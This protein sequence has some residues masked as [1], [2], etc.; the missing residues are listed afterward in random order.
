MIAKCPICNKE[1]SFYPSSKRKYCCLAC[2]PTNLG[3]MV[4]WRDKIPV[5]IV[6]VV[7]RKEFYVR[8]NKAVGGRAKYC[9]FKCKQVGCGRKGGEIIGNQLRGTGKSYPKIKGQHAH[10]TIAEKKLGRPLLPD[11]TVHHVNENK[12]DYSE[13]NLIVLPNQS[14]HIKLHWE[15]MMR[16]RREKHGY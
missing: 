3:N 6:C 12:L 8:P 16:R 13:T 4:R 7:C 11:E 1:F 9:S 5:L 2:V 14:A 10:R 15:E